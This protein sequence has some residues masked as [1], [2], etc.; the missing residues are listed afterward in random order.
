M[1][2]KTFLFLLLAMPVV[3]FAQSRKVAVLETVDKTGEISYATK[4]MVRGVF[5]TTISN[6]PGFEV[7]DRADMDAILS[8]HDFQRTGLVDEDQI[9]RLGE[10]TGA[11]YILVVEIANA[12]ATH[13]FVN[14]QILD[15]ETARMEMNQN[16]LTDNST[17][18]IQAACSNLA[19]R[20]FSQ[21]KFGIKK[22][23]SENLMFNSEKQ[24][25]RE[26]EAQRIYINYKNGR[27][28]YG[29]MSMD[30]K[31]YQV[32]LNE[33]CPEAYDVYKK[34]TGIK[35]AGWTFLG[36]GLASAGAAIFTGLGAFAFE[37]KPF[38]T[39][40]ESTSIIILSSTAAAAGVFLTSACIMIPTGK[41][42][43][44]KKSVDIF[45][46]KVAKSEPIQF[47]VTAS[48]NGL[49]VALNF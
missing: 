49:G 20:M 2:L 44:T 4:L 41:S 10:M 23:E 3:V 38:N 35:A 8:E 9:K 47:G 36:L 17:P 13:L 15:V 33:Y 28:E 14:A 30:K 12:D 31:G 29:K 37:M 45:N 34:G 1:K 19:N 48:G 25:A 32:F 27:Y 18:R 5:S 16:I 43:Q 42:M 40:S 24:K 39:L 22:N 26:I 46:A 21:K 11:Q 6:T 7:Y